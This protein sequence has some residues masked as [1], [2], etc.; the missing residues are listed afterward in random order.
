MPLTES[1]VPADTSS[2]VL[3]TTVGG[4]L[5]DAAARAPDQVALIEGVPGERR[6]WTYAELLADAERVA[7]ALAARFAKGDRVA[8][9]APNIPE[10][11]LLEYGAGLAGVVLVTVNPAYQPKE[12]RVRAA[13]VAILGHLLPALVPRQP[14][15]GV[16]Q[17]G[18][19]WPAGVARAHPVRRLRRVRCLGARRRR[20]AR[21][22]PGRPGCRSSTRRARRAFPRGLTCTTAG[23]LTTPPASSPSAW[24]SSLV[25]STS[26]RCR[27]F[28]PAAAC[29]ASWGRSSRGRLSSTWSSSTPG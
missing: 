16:A 14:D 18:C 8:V 4:I 13:A 15:G 28:T 10:W 20:T 9:W 22:E 11:V 25:A 26:T 1:Y 19:G 5:R 21:R 6:S 3:E 2:P 23:S 24:A 29:W 27:C 17:A 7:R 12:P